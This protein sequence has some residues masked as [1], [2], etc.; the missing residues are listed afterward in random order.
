MMII[1]NFAISLLIPF[2]FLI[3]MT[4]DRKIQMMLGFFCWGVVAGVI[5]GF[6]NAAAMYAS[7]ADSL[8]ASTDIAP[9]VE[10]IAKALPLVLFAFS[11]TLR[12]YGKTIIYSAAASGFGFAVLEAMLYY[13]Q[14]GDQ[15]DN[16]FMQLITRSLSTSLMHAMTT[17]IIGVGLYATQKSRQIWPPLFFGLITIS[18]TVHSIFNLLLSSTV[19]WAALI[20]P[21]ILYLAGIAFLENKK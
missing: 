13:D 21:A 9:L 14:Q 8:T 4:Y 7:N 17:C 15:L 12:S 1:F 20:V 11:K 18:Y 5:S 16:I 19:P 6:I 10:E 2:I 3:V